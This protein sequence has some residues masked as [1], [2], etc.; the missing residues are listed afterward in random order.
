MA[1]MVKGFAS[2]QVIQRLSNRAHSV[3]VCLYLSTAIICLQGKVNII[4]KLRGRKTNTGNMSS[5]SLYLSLSL[6]L[7]FFCYIFSVSVLDIS[8]ITCITSNSTTFFS[9]PIHYFHLHYLLLLQH[10][11]LPSPLPSS[12]TTYI[13]SISTTFFSYHIHYF[14]LHYLLLLPHTLLPS[15][16]PSSLAYSQFFP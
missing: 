12:P 16:L 10:T 9:Y 7:S 2:L 11:L 8:P 15:P 3:H 4:T 5:L 14:L 6:S 1:R 13:T